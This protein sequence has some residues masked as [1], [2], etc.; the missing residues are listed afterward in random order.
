M[1]T[2]QAGTLESM[3]CLV[4]LTEAPSGAGIKI[5]ITGASAAR[6]KSAM[7]KKITDTLCELGT[8]DIEVRVQDNGALDIVLGARVEAAY[9]RLQ[10]ESVK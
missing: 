5:E 9:K 1:K 3:D 4:T 6:F 7:E 10:K 8:K 2:S